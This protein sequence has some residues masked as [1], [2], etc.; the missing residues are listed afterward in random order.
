MP[1][2]PDCEQCGD[3]MSVQNKD[4]GGRYRANCWDCILDEANVDPD[5][6]KRQEPPTY[7]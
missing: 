1:N 2:P 4:K 6:A 7:E 5:E 3:Q